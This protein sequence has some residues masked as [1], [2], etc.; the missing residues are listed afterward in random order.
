MCIESQHLD[1]EVKLSCM[2][3]IMAN[4]NL[5][6]QAV[7]NYLNFEEESTPPQ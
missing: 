1:K 3:N 5:I 2:R 6:P 4:E 7:S